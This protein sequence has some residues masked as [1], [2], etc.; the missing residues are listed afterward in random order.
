[1]RLLEASYIPKVIKWSREHAANNSRFCT[2]YRFQLW[3]LFPHFLGGSLWSI[4]AFRII[5]RKQKVAPAI[6]PGVSGRK[7]R[8]VSK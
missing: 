6:S 5:P 1:M 4:R 7:M 8:L 2:R 3:G